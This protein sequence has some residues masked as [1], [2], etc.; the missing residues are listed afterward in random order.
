MVAQK[1]YRILIVCLYVC[2]LVVFESGCSGGGSGDQTGTGTSTAVA[3]NF[4]DIAAIPGPITAAKVGEVVM[5]DDRKSYSNSTE[6]LSYNWSFSYKPAGSNATLQGATSATPSFVADVSGVYMLQ[7]VV[8]AQGVS[9]QRAV[10]SVIVNNDIKPTG[11]FN[12]QGLSSNCVNCHNDNYSTIQSRTPSHIATSNTCQTCHTPQGFNIIPAVDH[13]EVFGGCSQC[14]DGVTAIGKSEFHQ[15]TEADCSNCHNTIAFLNLNPDGSFDHSGIGRSCSGCHNGMVARGQPPSIADNPPGTHPDTRSECGYCHITASFLN[16]YPDHTGPDVVGPGIS[17]DSCHVADGSGAAM[18]Q[19]PGHPITNVDCDTC[20]SIMSFKM[21]GGVFNHSLVDPTVQPCESCHND[22]TSIN[23]PAKSSAVPTHPVTSADCGTCHNTE[24][25]IPAF[26]IDHTGIVDNC[27]TCHGNNNAVS[28]LVTATGKPI[29]TPFYAHMPTNPDNPGTASDQDCGDCHTPGT[30]STG[31]YDHAGVSNGCNACHD[32]RISVGKLSN[33]IPTSP[34]SQDCADCHNTVSFADAM[35]NHTGITGNCSQCHD[36][37]ISTGKLTN[38]LPTTQDC[39]FCHVTTT[40]GSS[41]APFRDTLNFNHTGIN[42]DCESC[43]NGNSHFVAVGAIGKISNHIPAANVCADC[44]SA[45][46]TGGFATSTFISN[47]HPGITSG[48]EGCHNS[49]FL[50]TA[51]GNPNVVKSASHLPTD[52]DCDYCHVNSTFIPSI[53]SHVGITD[54]CISCHDGN[55]E[56]V[57]GPLGIGALGK[58]PG[59]SQGGTHPDTNA[60]CG[61]CHSIASGTFTDAIFDHT[62]IVNDCARSGCHT[63]LPGEAI[64]KSPIHVPTSDDCIVCHVAGGNFMTAVFDHSVPS[65]VS[66]RCDSCH[67]GIY[68]TGTNAKT[69]PP[70][71]NIFGKDCDACHVPGAGF[72]GASYDHTGIVDNCASC[73][74]GITAMGKTP[75]PDHVP[76]SD[77]CSVCHATTGFLPA[78]FDHSGIVDNC[79]AC[80][81]QVFAIGKSDTHV[82]TNQ[83][84]GVCHNTTTFTGATFDHT[85]IVDNC[86]SCHNGGTAIGKDAKTNPPHIATALDCHYCHTTATFIGGSWFH[87]ASTAGQCDS[88]HSPGNGATPKSQTHLST[89][90]QCDVCHS[91]DLWEPFIFSHSPQGDYP[92]DH[93]RDPGCSGC[94]GSSVTSTIPYPFN[95]YAPYCAACHAND[96]RSKDRH[97][98]G[99]SGTVE[100]NKDCS[101]GGRGCHRVSDSNFD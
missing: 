83:D 7:L 89:T 59:V 57:M 86:E 98:G 43:H 55:W 48:C 32:N 35:F 24:S 11:P 6:A 39:S 51:N 21:P 84:C 61:V 70:H 94:H 56:S 15:P 93:R 99:K 76:T 33:H 60:D 82:L 74:D 47:V 62:G 25:F 64:G 34:D 8:S 27:Q 80:H 44:H 91:T 18:G 101:G 90:L 29:S 31:T 81:N 16:A 78:T 79:S 67:D 66:A 65:V 54:N 97:N 45:T 38:H 1:I 22:S 75:P 100:Q 52:Q 77:D 46:A 58:T 4:V 88:C 37:V 50:P 3:G 10:T 73:H 36:G 72:A 96:F 71:V 87:D 20:H 68:A 92:G 28:P 2:M 95:Q 14:H 17:C 41:A 49:P 42:S 30:F 19:I 40:I 5:L 53:F 85:G 23:A 69:N 9:S 13:R 12:H 63:G 26:G